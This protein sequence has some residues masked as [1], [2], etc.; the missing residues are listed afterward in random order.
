MN[1]KR[2]IVVDNDGGKDIGTGM[3]LRGKLVLSLPIRN[4]PPVG[5]S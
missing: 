2:N 5:P 3:G 4:L 1:G